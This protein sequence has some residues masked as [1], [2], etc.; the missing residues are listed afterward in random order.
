MFITAQDFV[1]KSNNIKSTTYP[2]NLLT[3][4]YITINNHNEIELPTI[5]YIFPHGIQFQ[6]FFFKFFGRIQF[7]PL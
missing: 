4:H 1:E 5:K 2:S 6:L 7:Q 3:S